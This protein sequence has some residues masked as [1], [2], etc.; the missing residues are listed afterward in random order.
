MS[1]LITLFFF[2]GLCLRKSKQRPSWLLPRTGSCKVLEN[3]ANPARFFWEDAGAMGIFNLQSNSTF[4][5][6]AFFRMYVTFR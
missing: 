5:M 1:S 2:F 3:F 4:T 6:R